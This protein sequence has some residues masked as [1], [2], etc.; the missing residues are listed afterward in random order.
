MQVGTE[1]YNKNYNKES[2]IK[3][4]QTLANNLFQKFK[5]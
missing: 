2:K 4:K 3:V 1:L 5:N